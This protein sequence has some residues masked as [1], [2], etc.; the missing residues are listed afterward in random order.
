MTVIDGDIKTKKKKNKICCNGKIDD[1]QSTNIKV[2]PSML[3]DNQTW[4][5]NSQEGI[6]KQVLTGGGS[7]AKWEST[8]QI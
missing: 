2:E 8:G 4:T 6:T 1:Y 3:V 5:S 7:N